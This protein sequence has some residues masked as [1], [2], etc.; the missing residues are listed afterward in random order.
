MV[1]KTK[2]NNPE[3]LATKGTEDE[4]SKNTIYVGNHSTQTNTN[5]VNKT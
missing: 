1:H 5:N 2:T 3:K 4:Q